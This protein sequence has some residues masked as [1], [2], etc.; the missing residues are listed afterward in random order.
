MS[1]QYHT[2]DV[3]HPRPSFIGC[4]LSTHL[5]GEQGLSPIPLSTLRGPPALPEHM[6][7]APHRPASGLLALTT[8]MGWAGLEACCLLGRRPLRVPA[9]G[10]DCSGSGLV[11]AMLLS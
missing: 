7:E 1:R 3:F 10:S 11:P 2:L 4:V 8:D 5:G 6:G 9:S